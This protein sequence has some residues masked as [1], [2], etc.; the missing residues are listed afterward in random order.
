MI[1]KRAYLTVMTVNDRI[2]PERTMPKM[3]SKS[4]FKLALECPVKLYYTGKK[5]Y[6]DSKMDDPFLAGL[7]EGGF[8]VGALAQLYYPGGHL[9]PGLDPE[10]ALKETNELLKMDEVVIFEAAVRYKN[11][12]IR[13]DILEK[14]GDKIKLI[15]VK[16]KS[17]GES[18]PDDF[19]TKKDDIS[20]K[21]APY[22]F[23]AVFQKHVMQSA[24]PKYDIKAFLM[25]A[26]KEQRATVNGLNQLFFLEE[27]ADGRTRVKVK[28]TDDLGAR[29]LRSVD[30]VRAE[31]IINR[32]EF[33]LEGKKLSFAD[34]IDHLADAYAGDRKIDF[35]IGRQCKDCEFHPDRK[36]LHK[37]MKSGFEE[38]WKEKAGLQDRDFNEQSIFELW[39]NRKVPEMIGN[40]IYFLK[41][42]RDSDLGADKGNGKNGLTRFE[43]QKLQIEKVIKNDNT[44]YIDKNGIKAEMGT[45]EYPLHFIDFETTMAAIPFN[46][47]RRPYEVT[48]FQFSHHTVDKNGKVEHQGEY[49]N[50]KQGEFPNYEFIRALKKELEQDEGSIFRY[51]P[52]ENTVLN[53]VYDQLAEEKDRIPDKKE[54]MDFICSITHRKG[55]NDTKT[56]KGKRDMIDLWD[57]VKRFY[58]H[59][60]MKGSNSIKDV[61]PTVMESVVIRDKYSKPVYGDPMY[62]KSHNFS[63]MQWV[64]MDE[65]GRIKSPYDL[66]PK[67]FEGIDEE[68]LDTF[69]ADEDLAEGGAAMMAYCRMQFTEMSGTER[70]K[71]CEGLLRYCELDT[72]A[73]VMLYE[74]FKSS[75]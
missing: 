65:T 75:I 38:C 49:L 16:A 35:P 61:L 42:I 47:G 44:P 32:T 11:L 4:R 9:V 39:D 23:D 48:A 41:D 45:W 40:G 55:D 53:H 20:S 51:S 10:A 69:I 60:R 7:A 8:Q 30:I 13:A 54:L 57:L 25:L 73:M 68:K 63:K 3:L 34:Y 36:N 67:L 37:G 74:Y 15:E 24:F 26:D 56:R 64:V 14:K 1:V 22:L 19:Y 31:A 33:E 58:Y 29:I 6:P 72:L 5:E 27:D 50:R 2:E 28:R 70:D 46:K 12:F 21:W 43:R 62:S 71:I 52:H 18:I 66:L 17:A 59:P